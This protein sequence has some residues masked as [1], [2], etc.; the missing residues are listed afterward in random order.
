MV[1]ARRKYYEAVKNQNISEK[2]LKR[3]HF[4][5]IFEY[6]WNF[7]TLFT[8][9]ELFTQINGINNGVLIPTGSLVHMRRFTFLNHW[10]KRE[11]NISK[12]VFSLSRFYGF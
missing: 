11:K 12:T 1:D 2:N 3:G 4:I 6:N 8:I 5:G 9:Y 7:R 10:Y